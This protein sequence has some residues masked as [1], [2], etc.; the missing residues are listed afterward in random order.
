MLKKS[1]QKHMCRSLSLLK[2]QDRNTTSM[3]YSAKN[4]FKKFPE[5]K[6][7]FYS[8]FLSKLA[9]LQL[10]TLFKIQPDTDTVSQL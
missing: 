5:K 10:P 3:W 7:Q 9:C 8:F 2:L 6:N 4:R 1:K